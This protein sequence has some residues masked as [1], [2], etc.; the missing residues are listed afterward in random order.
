MSGHA[1]FVQHRTL[2]GKRSEVQEVWRR[3]MQPAIARNEG[4]FA[5]F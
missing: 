4:H 2:P 1:L 5:Y 3:H